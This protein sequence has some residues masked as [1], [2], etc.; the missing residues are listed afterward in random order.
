LEE[1]IQLELGFMD[2]Q[3]I[4]CQGFFVTFTEN[5]TIRFG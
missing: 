5:R 1:I 2:F 3:N 4:V